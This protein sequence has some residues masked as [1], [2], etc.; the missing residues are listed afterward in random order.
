MCSYLDGRE[1]ALLSAA[2]NNGDLKM[3][4]YTYTW[5]S[6]F[7]SYNYLPLILNF[8]WERVDLG[9]KIMNNFVYVQLQIYFTLMIKNHIIPLPF[10]MI[11]DDLKV[12]WEN[13]FEM[14]FKDSSFCAGFFVKSLDAQGGCH[15]RSSAW[16]IYIYPFHVLI[17][18]HT[19]RLTSPG[20]MRRTPKDLQYHKLSP[21]SILIGRL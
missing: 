21:L 14:H 3:H 8:M 18:I 1:K 17:C 6:C 12:P 9:L 19:T 15:H 7:W 16:Q 2:M 13:N 20:G 10:I 4:F 5:L 11:E